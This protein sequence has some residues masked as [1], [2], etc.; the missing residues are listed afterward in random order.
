[1]QVLNLKVQSQGHMILNCMR[2]EL[3]IYISS[4]FINLDV[5]KENCAQ[6]GF[7]AVP[8]VFLFLIRWKCH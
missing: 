3:Y 6:S 7:S 1:M 4:H 8:A 2:S 5:T